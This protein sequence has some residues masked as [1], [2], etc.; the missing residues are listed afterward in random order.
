L[1]VQ[2]QPR[3]ASAGAPVR[4]D[5]GIQG[6]VGQA[7]EVRTFLPMPISFVLGSD[8]SDYGYI[9]HAAGEVVWAGTLGGNLAHADFDLRV[10][11]ELTSPLA[12]STTTTLSA[13]GY[14]PLTVVRW[15]VVNGLDFYLPLAE[16]TR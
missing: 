3:S 7:F 4:V 14:S 12:L 5:I 15:L 10:S 8:H 11:P 9:T 6:L 13:F 1:D 2:L 16:Y